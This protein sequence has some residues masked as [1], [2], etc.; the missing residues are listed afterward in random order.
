MNQDSHQSPD[1]SQASQG[2][3]QMPALGR[4]QRTEEIKRAEEVSRLS[5]GS[6]CTCPL[7]SSSICSSSLPAHST[8][9]FTFVLSYLALQFIVTSCS[10]GCLSCFSVITHVEFHMLAVSTFTSEV[11][12]T[13]SS[14]VSSPNHRDPNSL[15]AQTQSSSQLYLEFQNLPP[16]R[17]LSSLSHL[18]QDPEPTYLLQSSLVI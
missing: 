11:S 7:S 6:K 4:S 16:N 10:L 5:L 12:G 17:P 18:K 9:P 13:L 1:T 3:G 14:R 15:V 2:S 8:S